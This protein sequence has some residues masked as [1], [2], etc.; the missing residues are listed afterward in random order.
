VPDSIYKIKI[1][2]PGFGRLIGPSSEL[3]PLTNQALV[4][5]ID[6]RI[7]A[8]GILLNNQKRTPPSRN[9][10]MIR[11]SRSREAPVISSSS[12]RGDLYDETSI[13]PTCAHV[14]RIVA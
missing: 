8:A 4:G 2:P 6:K 12:V 13:A 1:N 7:L 9:R 5:D 3:R 11:A 10:S 14:D